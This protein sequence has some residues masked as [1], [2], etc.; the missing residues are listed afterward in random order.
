[1]KKAK[2]AD[3]TLYLIN[4]TYVKEIINLYSGNFND[5][6]WSVCGGE[7]KTAFVT[8]AEF[9]SIE[10]TVDTRVRTLVDRAAKTVKRLLRQR[11]R[12]RQQRQRRW[13]RTI[14]SMRC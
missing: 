1:M 10:E 9:D 8:E 3:S 4:E 12:P 14:R 5:A 11:K 13:M 7:A 2:Y 6:L